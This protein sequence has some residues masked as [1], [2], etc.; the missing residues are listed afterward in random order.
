VRTSP[1]T[2]DAGYQLPPGVELLILLVLA[3]LAVVVVLP[4]LLGF[5]AAPFR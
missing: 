2:R 3:V 5:A 4:A 1:S